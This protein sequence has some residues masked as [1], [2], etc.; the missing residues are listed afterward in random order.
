MTI[1]LDHVF[2]CC[3][4]AGPQATA[5][6]D[7]GLVEGSGNVHLGQGTSNRRFF[8]EGA[9]IELLWV[10]DAEEAQS[11]L[12][13]PTK[14]GSR[15]LGRKHGACPFGIAFSPAGDVVANPPFA[16]WAY[17]PKYLPPSKKIWFAQGTTLHEP[18][19]FYLAWPHPQASVAAQTKH[20]PNGLVRLLSASVGLLAGT[21]LSQAALA[22]Q[23]AGLLNFYT[24]D[25][26]ELRLLFESRQ[27]VV[28]DLRPTLPLV[29]STA[30]KTS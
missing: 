17:E 30:E 5:L 15:W 13:A 10:S 27:P 18:E 2:I 24:A 26:Y 22:V 12:T 7:I 9:F 8:F 25:Q 1:A 29:L 19:L 3:D 20:H 6:L 21:P 14:L 23:H 16:A 28:F 11:A 4:P